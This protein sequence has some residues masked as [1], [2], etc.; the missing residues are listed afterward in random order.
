MLV[1]KSIGGSMKKVAV[2]GIS[3]DGHTLRYESITDAARDV[4]GQASHISEC[5]RNIEHH[6]THKGYRWEAVI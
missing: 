4:D 1:P 2:V 3:N 5:I 6:K